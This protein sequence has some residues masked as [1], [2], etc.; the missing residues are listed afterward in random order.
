[1]REPEDA[2]KKKK[3]GKASESLPVVV[4]HVEVEDSRDPPLER[5]IARVDG[6]YECPGCGSTVLDLAEFRLH[7]GRKKWLVNCSFSCGLSWEVDPVP[8]VIEEDRQRDSEYRFKHGMS[9]PQYAGKT[10][11]EVSKMPDGMDYLRAQAKV[12]KDARLKEA[13]KSW[14]LTNDSCTDTTTRAGQG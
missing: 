6:H 7:E 12:A 3:K 5:F 11:T 8:G 9:K 2:P 4:S 13:V 1:M 14:L 10:I